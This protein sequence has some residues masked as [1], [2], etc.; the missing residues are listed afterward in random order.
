VTYIVKPPRTKGLTQARTVEELTVGF[1]RT[2]RPTGRNIRG[3]GITFRVHEDAGPNEQALRITSGNNST[4]RL[5]G[6]RGST[7]RI[8]I[9]RSQDAVDKT[10]RQVKPDDL[11]ALAVIDSEIESL[12]QQLRELRNN[13]AETA[14]SA[15]KRAQ[16]V[17]LRD[18]VAQIGTQ[19]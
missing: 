12:K 6:T 1:E 17:P 9:T 2:I 14:A 7:L 8:G 19:S 10:I 5:D 13:R 16:K 3:G 15:W 18:L 11:V 4:V